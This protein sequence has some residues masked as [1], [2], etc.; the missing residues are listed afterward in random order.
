LRHCQPSCA[1]GTALCWHRVWSIVKDRTVPGACQQ[2]RALPGRQR[3]CWPADVHDGGVQ[4]PPLN[5]SSLYGTYVACVCDV[6]RGAC[7]CL[8]G[9]RVLVQAR[10]GRA[11][12]VCVRVAYARV[13]TTWPL[14]LRGF[15]AARRRVQ[16]LL[17]FALL[18]F[19]LLWCALVCTASM[20]SALHAF[21]RICW[22]LACVGG[23]LGARLHLMADVAAC[24][25]ARRLVCTQGLVRCVLRGGG[26]SAVCSVLSACVPLMRSG[27]C[28]HAAIGCVRHCRP[29][30]RRGNLPWCGVPGVLAFFFLRPRVCHSL[31]INRVSMPSVRVCA[32]KACA[33]VHTHTHVCVGG[34]G[35][36][37]PCTVRPLDT[38]SQRV[39][40]A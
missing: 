23:P 14:A 31:A 25:P 37:R 33:H 30:L 6:C 11:L 22:L 1:C 8:C 18:C 34:G 32:S 9:L 17:S 13:Y 19:A 7:V 36:P 3:A 2:H 21:A 24:K 35:C 38:A 20:A 39:I 40:C 5:A 15:L 27:R 29:E 26:A 12:R 28:T 10:V 16:A 4:R